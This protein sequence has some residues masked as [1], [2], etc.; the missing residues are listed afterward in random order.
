MENPEKRRVSPSRIRWVLKEIQCILDESIISYDSAHRL[1]QYYEDRLL[2]YKKILL[3]IFG[4]FGAVLIG[5][6]VVL[7]IAQYWDS[8]PRGIKLSLSAIVLLTAQFLVARFCIF[9]REEKRFV[10]ESLGVFWSLA[11]G[12]FLYLVG[13]VLNLPRAHRAFLLTWSLA[14]LPVFYL[15][16]S[17]V[18]LFI[19]TGLVIGWLSLART[20]H[21]VAVPVY[22]LLA[23]I[24]P[25]FYWVRK[26]G[27]RS[28]K[29][30]VLKYWT[31]CSAIICL[32]LLVNHP[33]DWF[34]VPTYAGLLSILYFSG[35]LSETGEEKYLARPLTI[36]GLFGIFIHSLVLSRD[37][38]WLYY[39]IDRILSDLSIPSYAFIEDVVLLPLL[40]CVSSM[41]LSVFNILKNRNKFFLVPALYCPLII[42][43]N[44]VSMWVDRSAVPVFS[45][46]TNMYTLVFASLY[47]YRGFRKQSLFHMNVGSLFI[48][49]VIA[50]RLFGYDMSLWIRGV[51]FICVGAVYV[52]LNYKLLKSKRKN[53]D[54]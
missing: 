35:E 38:V 44:L 19:Y 54:I 1:T 47:V 3:Y 33:L 32:V 7:V 52:L 5:S 36:I 20:E 2:D 42:I 16:K 53:T 30:I 17:I 6:G 46:L 51:T 14:V 8:M 50:I 15:Q 9:S 12:G 34:L 24:V 13:D 25:F 29:F 11:F 26:E 37:D 49:A 23:A 31:A 41:V 27:K 28:V 18:S 43:F 22:G 4:T 48:L 40:L 39:H 45:W 10:N 21:G